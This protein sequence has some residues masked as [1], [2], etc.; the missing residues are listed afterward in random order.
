MTTSKERMHQFVEEFGELLQRY[1]EP[2]DQRVIC[3]IIISRAA[4]VIGGSTAEPFVE[5][6]R[7]A[8]EQFVPHD[9]T[10]RKLDHAL[11]FA[12]LVDVWRT[13]TGMDDGDPEIAPMVGGTLMST[14][15]RMAVRGNKSRAELHEL[16]DQCYDRA[17][18][19]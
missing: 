6:A 10:P 13:M 8:W 17:S 19:S 2:E 14:I 5:I 1:L 15:T 18:R 4:H 12:R 16:L 11:T 7:E 3:K 9:K